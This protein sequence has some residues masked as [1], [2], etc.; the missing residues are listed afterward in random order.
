MSYLCP[1]TQIHV[2]QMTSYEGAQAL[3]TPWHCIL[4][5]VCYLCVCVAKVLYELQHVYASLR[6]GVGHTRSQAMSRR[7]SVGEFIAGARLRVS[8]CWLL[9]T[10]RRLLPLLPCASTSLHGWVTHS[11]QSTHPPLLSSSH[12]PIHSSPPPRNG[13]RSHRRC[14]TE[15]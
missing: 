5:R 15:S 14:G 3:M 10:S 6:Y 2:R 4:R 7:F 8:A 13:V 9:S 12:S 11:G 1:N